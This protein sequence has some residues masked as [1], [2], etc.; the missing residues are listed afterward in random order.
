[1]QSLL[2][3]LQTSSLTEEQIEEY[4]TQR[5]S[6]MDSKAV[7]KLIREAGLP[8][9]HCALEETYGDGW[10]KLETRL[11]A[12]IGTGFIIALSG[13]RGTGKT[14]LAASCVHEA[15]LQRR[16]SR[17]KTTM[18]FFLDIKASF[19]SQSVTEKDVIAEYSKAKLL[20]LDEMQERGETPWEDRL[21]THLIDRRYG[22][23]KD[24]LLITNQSKEA[25]LESVGESIKSR[26]D[27]TGGIALCNWPSYRSRK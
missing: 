5:Q 9:K 12:K 1:M 27:E 25:F 15:A 22:M 16:S 2:A 17:Y 24:T 18:E 10:F 23:E 26:I 4:Y 13:G 7:E 19:K 20:I 11:K 14:R 21:L 3:R 6:D 8:E